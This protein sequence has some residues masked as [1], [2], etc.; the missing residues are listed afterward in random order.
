MMTATDTGL[1]ILRLC[2]GGIMLAHATNHLAL[3]G[4]VAGTA[5]WFAGLGLRHSRVQA[6]ASIVTEAVG[7]CGLLLGLLT[8]LA[9]AAC[10]GSMSVAFCIAHRK[11]GF[12]VFKDGY[13]Y[14][15]MISA[16]AVSIAVAGP[17]VASLDHAAGILIDGTWGAAIALIGGIGGAATLLVATW[18]PARQLS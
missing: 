8:P 13:E 2:V 11:N 16:V 7:G 1:L 14:V 4:K 9:A 17:G 10:I 12:F 6:W 5:R 18:R 15:L 3:G